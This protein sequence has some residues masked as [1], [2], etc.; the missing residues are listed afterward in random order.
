MEDLVIHEEKPYKFE[1]LLNSNNE[2]K[3]KNHLQLKLTFELPDDYPNS[4]PSIRVKNM[5]PDIINNNMILEFEK[6]ISNKAQESI[7]T[8]MLYEIC[9]ALREQ[10]I[11]MNEMILKKLKELTDM[12]S[13]DNSL[14]SVKVSDNPLT[15]TPVNSETF[16]KWC[17]MYKEKMRLLKEA[18]RTEKDLKPTGRQLFEARKGIIED[19]KLD[20]EDDEEFKDE[21]GGGP[22]EDDDQDGEEGVAFYDKALYQADLEEDVDFD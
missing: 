7:G 8:F 3:E 14:K 13:I 9:E 15:F 19:I 16:A 18:M 17:D 5:S 11:N 6:L 2:S 20:E 22:E 10:I 21:E 12:N 4:M 1:V